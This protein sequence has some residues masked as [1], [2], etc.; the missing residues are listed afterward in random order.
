MSSNCCRVSIKDKKTL[1]LKQEVHNK[2]CHK[3]QI[4]Y[5]ANT[6]E[7]DQQVQSVFTA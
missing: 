4:K 3:Y 6:T 1:C 7:L 2:V 5:C